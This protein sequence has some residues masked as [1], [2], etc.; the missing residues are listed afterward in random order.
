MNN[1]LKTK[2]IGR[3][4]KSRNS[5]LPDFKYLEHPNAGVTVDRPEIVFLTTYPPRECGIATYSEDLISAIDRKVGDSIKLTVCPVETTGDD[6]EYSPRIEHVLNTENEVDYL[7]LANRLDSDPNIA[8]LVVQHEF[9]LFSGNEEAFIGFLQMLNCPV[10]ITL[11]TVLPRPDKH[12]RGKVQQILNHCDGIIVMTQASADVLYDDYGVLTTAISVIP[13][14]THP[15]PFRDR[16]VLKEKYGLTGKKVLS[17]FGLLGPSKSIETSLHALPGIIAENPETMFLILGKTHPELVK[18]QGEDYRLSLERKVAEL[19][20]ENNVRFVNRFLPLDEL[21]EYLQLTDIYLFTSN[22]PGQA[23]SGTF[24]YALGCGCPIVSTPIPHAKEVLANGAGRIIGFGDSLG[25]KEAIQDLFDDCDTR[26]DMARSG[27]KTTAASAWEN[28]AL[29]HIRFFRKHA[30]IPIPIQYRRP[31]VKMDHLRKMTTEVGLIQFS[32]FDR[33]ALRSG[34][35]ADDNARA[36]IATCE[37]F[38]STGDRADLKYI[39]IYFNYISR[40]IRCNGQF[41]NYVDSDGLF[42]EQNENENLED[43]FGRA[44]WG[45]GYFLSVADALPAEFENLIRRAEDQ[46]RD[47]L[48]RIVEIRSPRAVAFIIK[49]LYY[50][51]T[52]D[53]AVCIDAQLRE[54]ANRLTRF[55]RSA[56]TDRWHWFER[57]LTYAN[58]V[59]PEALLMAYILTLD[60]TYRKFAKE[61]FDFLLSKTFSDGSIRV[62][63]NQDWLDIEDKHDGHFRGGEQPIDVTYTILALKLFHRIFPLEKYDLKM[64][65]AFDWF[66]GD[67]PIHEIIYNP[68]TGGCHDG[69]EFDNVNLN[70]GAESTVCYLLARMAMP[71]PAR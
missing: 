65:G 38:V 71:G 7:T 26:E 66:L 5:D 14:G 54:M 10:V 15:V 9:G 52:G 30:K 56:S 28:S 43:A 6:Y 51:T 40:C 59:L 62:I 67:N 17:T 4:K 29:T 31:S 18:H 45:I 50:Y 21:L 61:S 11:H 27:L 64:E 35:T 2:A 36:L 19:G 53:R 63:S 68:C 60:G 23:V 55:Y 32:R 8:L 34:Y 1:T 24:S 69:L 47:C 41:F 20:L 49:G 25:L 13:H 58:A 44:F 42:T 70:Q 39:R 48:E 46:F 3:P 12:L 57:N 16:K 33:P 37:H 22:D